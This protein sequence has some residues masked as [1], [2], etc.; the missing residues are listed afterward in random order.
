MCTM[1]FPKDLTRVCWVLL[2]LVTLIGGIRGEL[3]PVVVQSSNPG[4]NGLNPSG[5]RCE[6]ITIPM[7]KGIGYNLTQMPNDLNHDTQDEAGLEVHQFWP[8][9]EIKCSS[10]LKFFLCS[11]YAPICIEDYY[12][13]LPVC[14]SVCERARAGCEPLM[15]QY[16]FSWP[17]RMACDRLPELGDPDNLCMEQNE[18]QAAHTTM[19]PPS[20]GMPT[21]LGK[22]PP[23]GNTAVTKCRN[24]KCKE[25]ESALEDDRDC[26][27]KC[28]APLIPIER[29]SHWFNRSISVS[30]INNCAYP[31]Q[32]IFF[33][34]PE[35]EFASM[36]IFVMSALCCISTLMTLTTFLIDTERFKYPE[37]PIVFLSGCYFMVSI[38][39][40]IRVSVGH[41]EV[42]CENQMVR[43]GASGPTPCTL[44]FLLVYFFGMSSYIW[45][46]ILSFTWFLAAGLK[47]GN[48]AIASYSLYFH[49]AA[50]LIPTVKSV[51]VIIMSA[52]DGDTIAGICYVGNHNINNLKYFVVFPLIIYLVL[53]II[54]LFGGFISLFR[55]RNVIKNQ[56]GI[57]NR[58]KADKLEK[59][60]IRI[61][62]FSVLSTLPAS[63]VIG[64]LIYESY[65]Y[66]EYVESI[67][68]PCSE[69]LDKD[70]FKP[71]HVVLLLKYFMA[72]AVGLTSGVWIWSG[73]TFSS[74]KKL[75]NR[76]FGFNNNTTRVLINTNKHRV[77][78]QH[79]Y[80]PPLQHGMPPP[81]NIPI[82][83]V[84][85]MGGG[86]HS[87]TSSLKQNPYASHVH[88]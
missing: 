27:C 11:M 85:V 61:G 78:K 58:T 9:V 72:L 1:A 45:W 56:G 77:L 57:S 8:L 22:K 79:D 31:C 28:R 42:A 36:W 6:E 39:Y 49:L 26:T 55:I 64:C 75:W 88:V 20:P 44:V 84:P 70:Y 33:S 29:D 51:S 60:M 53:G 7:C 66:N 87:M 67:V 47:W 15:Q 16:S 76:L 86:A 71:L 3:Q 32:G 25:S 82:P 41:E 17:E 52:V 54:F 68:C 5:G 43:Y 59:L 83:A 18:D 80:L 12:K 63:I 81:P 35:R 50:W 37:R 38:G 10:D 34:E 65:V 62:I 21:L 30:G 74:W 19:R 13:A 73:K 69:K 23:G 4:G 2:Y 24:G 40:L 14:R 48:E 46:V